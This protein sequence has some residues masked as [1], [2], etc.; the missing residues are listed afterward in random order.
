MLR[1]SL[2]WFLLCTELLFLVKLKIVQENVIF[3]L[4]IGS[5]IRQVLFTLMRAANL[6]K[7]IR[8]V[9]RMGGLIKGIFIGGGIH[10]TVSCPNSMPR[11]FLRWW[12]IKHGHWLAIQYLEIMF[13]HCFV[14]SQRYKLNTIVFWY[15]YSIILFIPFSLIDTSFISILQFI[16][17]FFAASS[18]MLLVSLGIIADKLSKL[19]DWWHG[20]LI[21]V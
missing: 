12:G 2:I 15:I 3:L 21:I 19:S 16:P 6:L 14:F 9:W 10:E 11:D 5:E 13:N 8:I 17:F 1:L 20:N 4:G 7:L 18:I